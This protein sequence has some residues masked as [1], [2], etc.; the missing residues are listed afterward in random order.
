LSENL[1]YTKVSL[2]KNILE[3][4]QNLPQGPVYPLVNETPIAKKNFSIFS[5]TW[6]P[7]YYNLYENST[8]ESP[9][10]G[11]R[12]ML[13]YKTFLGSKIMQTPERI[14]NYTFI[15]LQISREEGIVDP[16]VINQEARISLSKIQSITPA[17]SNTGIGQLG[18]AFSGVDLFKLDESIYPDIEVFWQY[19]QIESKIYGVIRLDRIL[20][21]YL[22]N[23][24]ISSVFIDNIISEYGVGNPNDIEDDVFSYIQ[25]NVVPVFE[26]KSLELLVL[27]RGTEI[28]TRMVAGDLVNP[29]KIKFGYVS[30]PN[31]SLTKRTSLTYQFEYQL[32][33]SQNYSLTFNFVT[34]KI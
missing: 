18:P 17:Q 21:R 33:K 34:E 8:V 26:G 28:P 6:D 31:Y 1:N 2:G 15:T 5:S 16:V 32:E 14:T 23:S 24:G 12:S 29:D 10:A 9:V 22:F 7:G 27:K 13:E 30:Q 3:A 19:N 20:K 25:Q 4:S 11:T